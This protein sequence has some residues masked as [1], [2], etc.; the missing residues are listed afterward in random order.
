MVVHRKQIPSESIVCN[1]HLHVVVN[2]ARRGTRER[3]GGLTRL[4][5]KLKTKPPEIYKERH[6]ESGQRHLHTVPSSEVFVYDLP[7]SQVAHSARNLDGHVNQVLLR[8]GLR[9]NG[10]D[11]AK[12]SRGK[13][14][15]KQKQKWEF[16]STGVTLLWRNVSSVSKFLFP[17][18]WVKDRS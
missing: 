17:L 14:Q 11:E 4:V 7:A 13:G 15:E 1:L 16:R 8:N 6:T 18:S 2:A 5:S 3:K 10:S 9:G 12:M